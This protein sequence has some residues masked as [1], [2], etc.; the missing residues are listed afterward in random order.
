MRRWNG[1]GD[2]KID[3]KLSSAALGFLR[4]RIGDAPAPNDASRDAVVARIPPSRLPDHRLV[5]REPEARLRASVG[6]SLEDWIR[7]R[8]G[9]VGAIVDGV[10]FAETEDDVREALD[11]AVAAGA[12]AIPVGGATSVVGHLTPG[13]GNRPSLAIAMAWLRGLIK[14]DPESL[15][16]IFEAGVTGPDLEAQLGARRF[17]FGHY[18]QSFEFSTLGGWIATRSCGSQSARYGRIEALFAGGR[19][20][21]PTGRLDLPAFP[22]SAAAPTSGNGCWD[23]RAE[24]GSSPG[25]DPRISCR[26]SRSSDI[27]SP[28][29]R[30]GRRRR[31]NSQARIGLSM[32]RLSGAAERRVCYGWRRRGGR[33]AGTLPSWRGCRRR[34]G[35]PAGR[36]HGLRRRG[37]GTPAKAVLRRRAARSRPACSVFGADRRE[38]VQERL[39][40]QRPLVGGIRRRR[41]SRRP[42]STGRSRSMHHGARDGNGGAGCAGAVWR[43]LPCADASLPGL[44]AGIERLLDLCVSRITDLRRTCERWRARKSG[45]QRGD[46]SRGRTIT[47]QHGVGK[48]RSPCCAAEKGKMGVRALRAMVDHFDPAGTLNSGNLLPKDSR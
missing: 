19:V 27:S 11:F 16:A 38:P 34:E 18:P 39:P 8:F 37:R 42:R 29:G 10:A 40:A 15:L 4:A 33:G 14:L 26:D 48:D 47:H 43:T 35:R 22:A 36:L 24:S 7:L 12:V 13:D 17:V 2:E 23:P 31:G 46:R 41:G 45:R 5:S 30:N 3:A 28:V 32:A 1:W 25:D 9:G 44:P 20:E 21:T 6:Q